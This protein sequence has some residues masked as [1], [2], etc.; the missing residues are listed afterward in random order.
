MGPIQGERNRAR[1]EQDKFTRNRFR[2]HEKSMTRRGAT[3]RQ[4][5]MGL[6]L[7]RAGGKFSKAENAAWNNYVFKGGSM[8]STGGGPGMGGGPGGPGEV[9]E[10]NL[11]EYDDRKVSALQQKRAAP[12]VRKLRNVTQ[13]VLSTT[14][15][16]P[17]VQKMTV[18]DALAGYGTGLENVMAGAHREAT[19]EYGQQYA[20]SVGAEMAKFNAA[21][22]RWSQ[23]YDTSS[24]AWLMEKDYQLQDQYKDDQDPYDAFEEFY[25]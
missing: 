19:Q 9:P 5:E 3:S 25:G 22:Q 16:N 20:A 23:M 7:E 18:R 1:W 11:P 8:P 15:E 17:N 24:R 21:N 14:H 6:A 10:L 13:Q 2:E 4:A 12:N